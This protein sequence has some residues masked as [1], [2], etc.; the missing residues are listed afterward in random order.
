MT[1]DDIYDALLQNYPIKVIMEKLSETASPPVT[2]HLA[3]N[4][5][6]IVS[7]GWGGDGLG[8]SLRSSLV[9][10]LF[11]LVTSFINRENS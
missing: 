9:K 1:H 8:A 2:C 4:E 5:D 10:S 6:V 7:E 11:R 3:N